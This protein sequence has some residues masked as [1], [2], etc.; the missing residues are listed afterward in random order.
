MT[1]RVGPPLG[2]HVNAFTIDQKRRLWQRFKHDMQQVGVSGND[3][4]EDG[5]HN[6]GLY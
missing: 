5:V 2:L 1:L 6:G 4:I 3:R